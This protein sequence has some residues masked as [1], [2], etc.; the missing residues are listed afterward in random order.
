MSG[1][2]A[3][4][5]SFLLHSA[6]FTLEIDFGAVSHKELQEEKVVDLALNQT[7]STAH[8]SP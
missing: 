6:G 3:V 5:G 2:G 4:F 8:R 1:L 7:N